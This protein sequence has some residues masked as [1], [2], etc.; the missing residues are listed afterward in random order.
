MK[1]ENFVVLMALAV[2]MLALSFPIT[3][4]DSQCLTDVSTTA[5]ISSATTGT[6]VTI[7][8]TTTG[9]SCT[10]STLSLVSSPSLTVNDPADGQYSGFTAGT[11]K[12]FTVTA[13]TAGTYTY[14]SRGTTSAGSV[15]STSTVL[16]FI[17]PSDMTV[18]AT[19]S[20]QSLT[21]N[22]LYNLTISVS[23]P[24]TSDVTTSYTLNL[25]SGL[26]RNSGDPA[27]SSGTTISAGSTNN[28]RF[29][30]KHST[31]FTGSKAITF[32]LGDSTAAASVSVS[33]NS[34]CSSSSSNSSSSSSS[35]GGGGGGG[36]VLSEVHSFTKI[37]AGVATV[38]KFTNTAL[39]LKE[40]TIEVNND[41]NNVKITVTKLSGQPASITKSIS[42]K[43]YQFIEINTSNLPESNIKSSK[44][45]F[46]V[47][48]S[49]LLQNGYAPDDV[50]LLRYNSGDWQK[51]TTSRISDD[52][53]NYRYEA[54]TPGFSTFAVAA[55]KTAAPAPAQPSANQTSPS[56]AS[57]EKQTAPSSSTN[58]TEPSAQIS[59]PGIPGLAIDLMTGVIMMIVILIVGYIYYAKIRKKKSA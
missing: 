27:S 22:N 58:Q 12:T 14:Y 33:G 16:D 15:D 20:S 47:T 25:P 11:A 5:S 32:D 41:A 50:V 1:A 53:N 36:T 17:S 4:A 38:T 7:T 18:S 21:E 31:C 44:L 34:S 9:T 19:P 6:S 48:K 26:T 35:S 8:A 28:M 2:A 37:T 13:G 29:E 46:D 59:I 23:N 54:V 39:G 42:G 10:V 45:A 57:S 43:T 30:V 3:Y 24:G 49:W 40:I 55:D 51:L 52:S 56:P